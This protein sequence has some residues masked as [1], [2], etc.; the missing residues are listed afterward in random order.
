[1]AKLLVDLKNLNIKIKQEFPQLVK[2]TKDFVSALPQNPKFSKLIKMEFKKLIV[3]EAV[4]GL[5]I[6]MLFYA[7][8]CA[9]KLGAAKT[10]AARIKELKLEI[11]RNPDADLESIARRLTEREEV[12][13][14]NLGILQGKSE[15]LAPVPAQQIPNVLQKISKIGGEERVDI[16]SIR[17]EQGRII[18]MTVKGDY[19]SLVSFLGRLSRMQLPMFTQNLVIFKEAAAY[20]RL[21]M[22][23]SLNVLTPEETA[24]GGLAVSSA[25]GGFNWSND[26]MPAPAEDFS[27]PP[28]EWGKGAEG[29]PGWQPPTKQFFGEELP[30]GHPSWEELGLDKD[31][32]SLPEG[33]TLPPYVHPEGENIKR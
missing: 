16:D 27:A 31:I 26:L 12:F 23:V 18:D 33:V 28:P 19:S 5:V 24:A 14:K 1:M 21:N 2:K 20:P 15:Y 3:L 6:I 32:K 4:F 11:S 13:N 8:L 7:L 30:E 10:A 17:F 29:A 9:P 25:G 22:K